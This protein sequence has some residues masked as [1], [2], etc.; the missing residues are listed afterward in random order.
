MRACQSASYLFDEELRRKNYVVHGRR[1]LIVTGLTIDWGT[2]MLYALK[3]VFVLV[4]MLELIL[5]CTAD[6]APKLNATGDCGWIV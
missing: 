4:F 1:I 3:Y 5:P 6:I 2:T